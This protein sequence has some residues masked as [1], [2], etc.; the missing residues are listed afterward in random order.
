M[1]QR[2][3]GE[4]EGGCGGDE[5][6][7]REWMAAESREHIESPQARCLRAG[8]RAT[9]TRRREQRSTQAPVGYGERRPCGRCGGAPAAAHKFA[10][11]HYGGA[12][13][14]ARTWRREVAA[15][16]EGDS[17]SVVQGR[18]W[19]REVAALALDP[20]GDGGEEDS[21]PT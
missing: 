13:V 6:A 14:S 11:P 1:T 9:A 20:E 2:R 17:G 12:R 16:F 3:E 8:R 5:E 7:W 18:Q 10:P 19:R 15:W 4:T 21:E